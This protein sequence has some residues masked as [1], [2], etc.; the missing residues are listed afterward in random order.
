MQKY[1]V[2]SIFQDGGRDRNLLLVSILTIFPKSAHYFAS[3]YRL[4]SKSEHPL[5]KYDVMS[6]SQDGGRDR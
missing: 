5:R 6:I 1:D 3:G 2:I 4:S